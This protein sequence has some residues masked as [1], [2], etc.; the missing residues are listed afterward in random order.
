MRQNVN[1][2]NKKPYIMSHIILCKNQ[3]MAFPAEYPVEN[4]I[5]KLNP[6][7]YASTSR[8]SPQKYNPLIFLL[9]IVFGLTSDKSTP[10]EVTTASEKPRKAFGVS[11]NCFNIWIRFV[12][13]S[14]V[15]ELT[16]TS[17]CVCARCR[18]ESPHYVFQLFVFSFRKISD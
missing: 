11:T 12:R 18:Q 1:L 5:C 8:T 7:V 2:K 3:E 9:S 16:L 13:I 15:T 10:P 14:R 17:P 4:A 6:P